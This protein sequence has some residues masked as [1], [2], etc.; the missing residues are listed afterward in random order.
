MLKT[1]GRVHIGTI[2]IAKSTK[3]EINV[4]RHEN[5]KDYV[6]VRT[7]FANIYAGGA[8]TPTKKGIHIPIEKIDALMA[9]LRAAVSFDPSKLTL[10][11]KL[12]VD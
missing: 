1:K 8:W 7:W 10:D 6:D 5:D 12:D 2:E 11:E 4:V 3:L 9:D